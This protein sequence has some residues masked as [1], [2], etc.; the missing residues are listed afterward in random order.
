MSLENLLILATGGFLSGIMSGL[1]GIGGGFIVVPLLVSLGYTPIQ[2]IATSTL[3]IVMSSISGSVQ[4]WLMG[5]LD[6]KR[7]I[8]LGVPALVTAPI[9]VYLVDRIPPYLLLVI[10]GVFLIASIFLAEIR[11]SLAS[12]AI[13]GNN[14]SEFNPV[15]SRIGTGGVTGILTGLLGVGGGTVLVPLQMLLL[16][17]PI[18]LAIQTSLGVIVVTAV[19]ACTEYVFEGKVLFIQ[20]LLL[21]AGGLIGSQIST[22]FLPK[23][24]DS[25]V[26]LVFRSF[27]GIMSI[28][29][30]WQAWNFYHPV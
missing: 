15:L 24:S 21:G 17:E 9:G 1:L 3:V 26:L 30:F 12:E 13:D 10:F 28:Y 8:Q 6:Y 7:V 18:K 22:R 29:M 5:Y 25:I 2:A 20:G 14:E 23:L 11:K 4:N 27:L 16:G 19:S